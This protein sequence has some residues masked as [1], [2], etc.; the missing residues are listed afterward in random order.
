MSWCMSY[1]ELLLLSSQLNRGRSNILFCASQLDTLE[2]LHRGSFLLQND[3]LGTDY[4]VTV[5]YKMSTSACQSPPWFSVERTAFL[6]V[7]FMLGPLCISVSPPFC[8]LAESLYCSHRQCARCVFPS[9]RSRYI[10]GHRKADTHP[11]TLKENKT[12]VTQTSGPRS[13]AAALCMWSRGILG[14]FGLLQLNS[15]LSVSDHTIKKSASNLL[16]NL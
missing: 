13:C 5:L 2:A 3:C 7:C 10:P 11:A 8:P 1:Y 9:Q 4:Q 15:L 6:S 12:S 14:V 16:P